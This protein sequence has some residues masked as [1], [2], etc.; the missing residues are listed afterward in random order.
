MKLCLVGQALQRPREC[1]SPFVERPCH[2][3]RQPLPKIVHK[4]NVGRVGMLVT[5]T[6]VSSRLG[7]REAPGCT[8]GRRL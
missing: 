3:Q 8:L 2:E 1:E 5:E 4:W 7:A 6:I